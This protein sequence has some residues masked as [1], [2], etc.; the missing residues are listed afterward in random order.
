VANVVVSA[1][2]T[3]N[4]KALKKA[5]QDVNVFDKQLK[6]L[7]RTLGFTFSATAIVAFSKKAVKAFAEDEA[8]AKSLQLQLENTGNAFRVTEVEAYIK[9]LEKTNA[10]LT[11]LRAPFQTL[12]NVTG[13]VDLAQRSL[14]AALDISAGTGQSLATVIGAISAGVR[15]QTKAIKGLNTGIDESILATGDMNKIM[16]ELERRFAG[17]AAARL[18]TYA[19]KMDALKKSADEAT[20]S[21]GEGIVDALTILSEDQSID[22]LAN[23]FEN[24]GNNIAFTITQ[25]AKLIDKFNSFTNSPSFK[26]ALLLAGAGISVATGNPAPFL[27]AF[28]FVG[29]SGLAGLATKDFSSKPSSNFTYGAGNPRADLL[30]SKN[31][32]KARKEEFK[33]INQ[34]NAIENKNLEELKKKFDLERIGLT[35]AL[36][37]ATDEETKLRL[38]A[39]LA[40]LDE[41]E[42]MAKKLLAEM[43]ASDALKKLAEQARLAGLSLQDFALVSVRNLI[44][45]I[46]SQIEAIN[47][48]A[49]GTKTPTITGGGS[50]MPP[51]LTPYDPLS[52]L[53]ATT[54]D[55]ADT[56]FRYD[57]LSGMRAT[58]Q[59]IRITVDTAQSGDR[60]AQ[61]I[62]ESIQVAGRSGYNTSANGSLPV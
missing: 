29:A 51:A 18:G 13:S 21:I 30:V 42:A 40:I 9:G 16:K 39:Q 27:A 22:N 57:P 11:D 2:A 58:A 17:Q 53:M 4:G 41:N 37:V 62:A 32:V 10:I 14:E 50:F 24:L 1:L 25:M 20:K 43:E 28:G 26:P 15:G 59:D 38:R 7:A 31:L 60:F 34:K 52:S 47:L 54:Q 56:G 33:I 35:Q 49:L 46:N 12:L 36:N 55:L 44:A 23:S 3:W 8:A 5:K 19:G 6:S 61:F 48:L 45:R